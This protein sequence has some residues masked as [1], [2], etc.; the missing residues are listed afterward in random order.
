MRF[1]YDACFLQYFIL[2]VPRDPCWWSLYAKYIGGVKTLSAGFYLASIF[3]LW[4]YFCHFSLISLHT[5]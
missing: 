3:T 2:G 1:C 5:D 4:N